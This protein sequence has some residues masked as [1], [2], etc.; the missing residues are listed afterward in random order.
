MNLPEHNARLPVNI[1]F[2]AYQEAQTSGQFSNLEPGT[3]VVFSGGQLIATGTDRNSL[4]TD[5]RQRGVGG[6]FIKEIG[7]DEVIDI[8]TPFIE[9]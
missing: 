8:P 6:A 5:L 1:N 4:L 2:K 3:F 7:N 9:E